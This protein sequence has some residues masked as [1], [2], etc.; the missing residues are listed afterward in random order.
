M[1][2]KSDQPPPTGAATPSETAPGP[3]TSPMSTPEPK[4][5]NKEGAR[6]NLGMALDL[7]EQALP[8]LGSESPEGQK[9]VAAM[10]ALVGI[11]GPQKARTNELQPAEIMQLLGS[12]PQAGN[13]TPEVSAILGPKPGAGAPPMPPAGGPPPGAGAAPPSPP[14]MQ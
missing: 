5:G 7:I 6:V 4:M 3:M 13:V 11:L 12:L 14:P 1:P 2:P 8:S 9:A 10:R